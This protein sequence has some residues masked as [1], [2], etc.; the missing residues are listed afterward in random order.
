MRHEQAAAA[1]AVHLIVILL[2]FVQK[3]CGLCGENQ[4][5]R[6]QREAQHTQH[7]TSGAQHATRT[8]S[9]KLLT[10]ESTHASAPN[11]TNAAA[12]RVSLQ[13]ASEKQ[14]I[15]TQPRART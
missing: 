15:A 11:R 1:A 5:L 6:K 10:N 13:N 14:P 2:H 12:S 7:A 4:I 8:A 3:R 9:L